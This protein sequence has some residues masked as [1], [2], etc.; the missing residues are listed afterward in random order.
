MF[1]VRDLNTNIWSSWEEVEL[2]AQEL[3]VPTVPVLSMLESVKDEK[4]LKE[5]TDELCIQNSLYG[6]QREGVVVRVS[7]EFSNKDFPL[8]VGKVVRANHITTDQHWRS[9]QIIRNRISI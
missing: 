1:A 8:L 3:Q 4:S 2:W 5:I 9:K 6:S 7:R